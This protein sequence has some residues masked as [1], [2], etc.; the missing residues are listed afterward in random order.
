MNTSLYSLAIIIGLMGAS[1]LAYSDQKMCE[2][3]GVLSG[4]DDYEAEAWLDVSF[5]DRKSRF[6]QESRDDE[7]APT[8]E[9]AI[10]A[11]VAELDR[12]LTDVFGE[13]VCRN[14]PMCDLDMPPVELISAD[15]RTVLCSIQMRWPPGLSR[16]IIGQQIGLLYQLGIDHQ[17]ESN[18]YSDE[19]GVVVDLITRRRPVGLSD[20]HC[21]RPREI[22]KAPKS[23]TGKLSALEQSIDAA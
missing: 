4:H 14:L 7:W 16:G 19:S 2:E 15:C 23:E 22:S 5:E 21:S 9:Q 12:P 8:M 6:E 13:Q 17:G 10:K 1:N 18:G 20:N 3:Y 11:K